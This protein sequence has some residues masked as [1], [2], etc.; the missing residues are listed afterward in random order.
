MG[1]IFGREPVAIAGFIAIA[2]NLGIAFGLK[3]TVEQVALINTLV[4]A[5]LALVVRQS[6]YAPPTVQKIAD[7]ATFETAGTKVD[8]GSPPEG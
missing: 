3:L 2:I 7:A 1:T 5:G 8:I 4:V 6:V